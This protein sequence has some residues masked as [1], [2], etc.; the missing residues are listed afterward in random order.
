MK[1]NITTTVL[2][3]AMIL[4]V[5]AMAVA[6]PNYGQGRGNGAGRG[7]SCQITPEKWAEVDAVTAK[8]ADQFEALRTQ[9]WAKHSVLQAMINKGDANEKKIGTLVGEITE[10][11]DKMRDLRET[12]SKEVV[13]KTGVQLADGRGCGRGQNRGMGQG[14]GMNQNQCQG[15]GYGMGQGRCY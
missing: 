3:A 14:R 7:V 10:L 15:Q 4:A 9:M 8:Y 6:G 12:V 1:K 13:E 11:R 5:S 2:A